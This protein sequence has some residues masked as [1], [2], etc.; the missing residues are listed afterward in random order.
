MS[1]PLGFS[2]CRKEEITDRD[3]VHYWSDEAKLQRP[4][5]YKKYIVHQKKYITP[6]IYA[7]TYDNLIINITKF[8][9][10]LNNTLKV[11]PNIMIDN[12]KY[13]VLVY[14]FETF[15]IRNGPRKAPW[16]HRLFQDMKKNLR[17]MTI[18]RGP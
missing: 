10:Y 9:G 1:G 11:F 17:L 7:F 12:T 16:F 13:Q 4:E 8:Q 5:T 3:S 2:T 15:K 6:K 18:L 14:E